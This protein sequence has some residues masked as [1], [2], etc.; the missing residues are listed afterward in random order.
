MHS[1]NLPVGPGLSSTSPA[2]SINAYTTVKINQAQDC[3]SPRLLWCPKLCCLLFNEHL[4]CDFL[5]D[6][7]P[8]FALQVSKST[9]LKPKWWSQ[10]GTQQ[11]EVLSNVWEFAKLLE[12]FSITLINLFLMPYIV[13]TRSSTRN[14]ENIFWK[15][16]VPHPPCIEL[17]L[18]KIN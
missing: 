2:S 4:D 10:L 18:G 3:L 1:P 16:I 6:I 9:I 8:M 13:Y 12:V 17:R 14:F 7:M 15:F 11:K 5:Q